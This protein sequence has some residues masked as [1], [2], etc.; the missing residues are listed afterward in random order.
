[1]TKINTAMAVI[2][3]AALPVL[4]P[5]PPLLDDEVVVVVEQVPSWYVVE[6]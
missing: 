1:M 5:E 6:P 3:K 2:I 4:T